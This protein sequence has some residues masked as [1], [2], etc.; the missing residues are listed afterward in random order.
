METLLVRHSL[1]EEIKGGRTPTSALWQLE[2][3][4][5]LPGIVIPAKGPAESQFPV[6]AIE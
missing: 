2:E 3:L 4:G 5:S 6:V 1:R